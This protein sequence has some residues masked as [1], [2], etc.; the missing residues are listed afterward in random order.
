[1]MIAQNIAKIEEKIQKVCN[2]AGRKRET[3]TLMGVSK[4]QPITMVEEARQAGIR[5]FG[6]SRVKEGIEKFTAYRKD[7]PQVSLHLIGTLQ[8]NKARP[9]AFFYD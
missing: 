8:R 1:M 3:I 2:T 9:A 5:Y 6:E 7:H 4:F